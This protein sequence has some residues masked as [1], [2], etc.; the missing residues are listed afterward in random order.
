MT[1]LWLALLLAV[2][3]AWDSSWVG[4]MMG[5]KPNPRVEKGRLDLG[6]KVHLGDLDKGLLLGAPGC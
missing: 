2:M 5:F 3:L 1:Y 6:N 4:G